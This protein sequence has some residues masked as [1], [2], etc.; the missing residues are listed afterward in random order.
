[1]KVLSD[2]Q[3]KWCKKLQK[4]MDRYLNTEQPPVIIDK[5]EVFGSITRG[6]ADPKDLDLIVNVEKKDT[7]YDF[8]WEA[9][10]DLKYG[11]KSYK[12]D[13]VISP[14]DNV[15]S[16]IYRQLLINFQ[17]ST[18]E[19]NSDLEKLAKFGAELYVKWMP[20]V[21]LD[22]F[23]L[24]STY[25]DKEPRGFVQ[26][27]EKDLFSRYHVKPYAWTGA[28][29]RGFSSLPD[30]TKRFILWT[31]EEPNVCE[32][33]K[34]IISRDNIVEDITIEYD[35]F[36]ESIS[37]V[38]HDM[39]F[40]AKI[41]GFRWNNFHDRTSYDIKEGLVDSNTFDEKIKWHV[42]DAR[43][44]LKTCTVIHMMLGLR[45]SGELKPI[46]DEQ[47]KRIQNRFKKPEQLIAQIVNF[48]KNSSTLEIKRTILDH[49]GVPKIL[50]GD[51]SNDEFNIDY[52]YRLC[53]GRP[54]N[55]ETD[56]YLW[57][58]PKEK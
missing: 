43:K 37:N 35:S 25:N 51:G 6:K 24:Y 8:L 58:D 5:V 23:E 44:N 41:L 4:S 57:E 34:K 38:N 15:S 55:K 49:I 40:L 19:T 17:K 54:W 50:A 3:T 13:F 18:K 53:Y 14:D 7:F 27:I 12:R 28:V 32:N 30:T 21:T 20:K 16:I 47:L 42:E 29:Q 11:D 39:K 52:F 2:I 56:G 9:A 36:V 45:A 33:L 46:T 22:W 48:P 10:T 26:S 31:P 1:M